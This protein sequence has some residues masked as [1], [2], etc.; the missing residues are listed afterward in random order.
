MMS[1]KWACLAILLPAFVK[2]DLLE[3]QMQLCKWDLSEWRLPKFLQSRKNLPP[4]IRVILKS[5]DAGGPTYQMKAAQRTIK[6]QDSW[7]EG[8]KSTA[9]FFRSKQLAPS[10]WTFDYE[11]YE[12]SGVTFVNKVTGDMADTPC[13]SVASMYFSPKGDRAVFL[14]SPHYGEEV[15]ELHAVV[16]VGKPRFFRLTSGPPGADIS[17]TWT[18]NSLAAVQFRGTSPKLVVR[19]FNIRD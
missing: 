4:E 7:Y 6:L 5:C 14:C 3:D 15:E 8:G 12:W 13:N 18:T 2:A 11:G 10:Y 19:K 9:Y 16:L 17:V 1:K